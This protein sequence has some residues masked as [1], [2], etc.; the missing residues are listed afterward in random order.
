MTWTSRATQPPQGNTF[1][2]G[3]NSW[4]W[5][6]FDL[7][8]QLVR[9]VINY[10]P[11]QMGTDRATKAL[12]GGASVDVVARQEVLLAKR[13]IGELTLDTYGPDH[14]QAPRSYRDA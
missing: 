2:F 8:P 5:A 11:L 3:H 10:A 1:A 4:I 14:P 6:Q 9:D 13:F 12:Q 7:L